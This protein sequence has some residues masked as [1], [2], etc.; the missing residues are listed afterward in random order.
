MTDDNLGA[1]LLL[2]RAI[3]KLRQTL[4]SGVEYPKSLSGRGS[5]GRYEVERVP[6]DET[7]IMLINPRPG[8]V[9]TPTWQV[10]HELGRAFVVDP[11]TGSAHWGSRGDSILNYL[12]GQRNGIFTVRP[13]P[14]EVPGTLATLTFAMGT[15]LVQVSHVFNWCGPNGAAEMTWTPAQAWVSSGHYKEYVF[16]DVQPN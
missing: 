3:E 2:D 11:K 9:R 6:G 4:D 15:W 1:T 14:M 10:I 8:E 13:S 7:N 12:R 16:V 5:L